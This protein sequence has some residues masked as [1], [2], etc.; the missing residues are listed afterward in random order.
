ML[1]VK[2]SVVKP[3]SLYSR[4]TRKSVLLQVQAR[5]PEGAILQREVLF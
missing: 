2:W 1:M 4:Q 5:L 3:I